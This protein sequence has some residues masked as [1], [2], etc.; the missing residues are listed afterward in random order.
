[1]LRGMYAAAA[2]GGTSLDTGRRSG[3]IPATQVRN[4]CSELK[5][6]LPSCIGAASSLS[7]RERAA[8]TGIDPPVGLAGHAAGKDDP[9]SP[10]GLTG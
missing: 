1:M 7:S 6:E 9:G 10:C 5:R 4:E 2:P 8:R 3:R